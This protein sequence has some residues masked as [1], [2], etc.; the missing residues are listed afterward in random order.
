MSV[1]VISAVITDKQLF[2]FLTKTSY[3][4]TYNVR[5]SDS[6]ALSKYTTSYG[7]FDFLAAIK[8][9]CLKLCPENP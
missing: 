6:N 8:D 9:K 7:I 3:F 2:F 4:I 5:W 1:F